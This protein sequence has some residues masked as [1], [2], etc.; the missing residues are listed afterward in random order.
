MT[1]CSWKSRAWADRRLAGTVSAEAR[2]SR[3]ARASSTFP[4]TNARLASARTET[5]TAA[6]GD[7]P[8]SAAGMRTASAA[9]THRAQPRAGTLEVATMDVLLST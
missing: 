7:W 9:I 2:P 8:E 4:A 6:R 5:S 3:R 1:A